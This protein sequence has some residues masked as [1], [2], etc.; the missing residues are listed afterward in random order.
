[1][2]SILGQLN[3]KP[4]KGKSPPAVTSTEGIEHATA[5]IAAKDSLDSAEASAEVYK[6]EVYAAA[7]RVYLAANIGKPVPVD[8]VEFPTPV[9]TV[10]ASFGTVWKAA[11]AAVALLPTSLVR[12]RFVISIDG[13]AM[14]PAQ[15]NAFVPALLSLAREHGVTVEAKG[16]VYPVPEFNARRFTEVTPEVNAAV[17]AAGLGTRITLRVSR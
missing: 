3:I 10:R 14:S 2:N 9:G 5:F 17:E 11:P 1:M 4:A 12:E 6:A 15:A 8:A 16:G 7:R 13:D